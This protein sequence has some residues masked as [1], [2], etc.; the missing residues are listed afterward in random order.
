TF[1]IT[2]GPEALGV[3]AAPASWFQLPTSATAD[4]GSDTSGFTAT[5][6]VP[7]NAAPGQYAAVLYALADIGHGVTQKIRIPVQFFVPNP[8]GHE[9]SA[10]IWASDTTDY[11]LVGFENPEAQIYSDWTM[12][13]VR[14]P[15]SGP[16]GLTFK[17][18]DEAGKSTMDVFVFDNAGNE[19]SSTVSND[20]AHAVP[21]GAAL[22]PTSKSSPGVA[23]V[24][25]VA[26]GAALTTG[27]V[28]AGDVV[29][30][31]VSDTKPANPKKFETYHL[32]VSP[33]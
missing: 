17:V 9:M 4:K 15:A 21:G 29:W 25:I 18:W 31:V 11:S 14:V 24:A 6:N 26:K 2:S 8:V 28:H 27:Q 32:S 23:T 7:T 13:P 20:P 3:H 10:P 5:V 22:T 16:A 19:V 33:S 30:V 12:V 1:S